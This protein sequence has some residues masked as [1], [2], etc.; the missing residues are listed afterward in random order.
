MR[1]LRRYYDKWRFYRLATRLHVRLVRPAIKPQKVY[2]ATDGTRTYILKTTTRSAIWFLTQLLPGVKDHFQST[3]VPEVVE[4][5]QWSADTFWCLMPWIEGRP[6][7]EVWSDSDP[8]EV[9]WGGAAITERELC[10][11]YRLVEDLV[12]A[13]EKAQALLGGAKDC[14]VSAERLRER[15]ERYGNLLVGGHLLSEADFERVLLLSTPLLRPGRSE[16]AFSN[17]DFQFRNFIAVSECATAVVDWDTAR[18]SFFELEHCFSY[19]AALLW[20]NVE[21]RRKLLVYGLNRWALDPD[22]LR[23]SAVINLLGRIVSYRH[24]NDIQCIHIAR[25]H[26]VLNVADI[27]DAMV[28]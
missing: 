4:F 5:G 16:L 2:Y 11:F 8:N 22:V 23:A 15:L 10:R 9:G 13:S 12:S 20:N 25:L 14:L 17:G 26:R 1:A 27:V 3:I 6:L 18:C 7:G 21:C 19:Q 24:R 28:D